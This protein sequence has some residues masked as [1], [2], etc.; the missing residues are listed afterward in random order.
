[1]YRCKHELIITSTSINIPCETS[2]KASPDKILVLLVREGVKER[3]DS[4]S[5]RAMGKD[6][7]KATALAHSE[8]REDRQRTMQRPCHV[9]A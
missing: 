4:E 7:T 9:I 3:L 1:M 5:R 2:I 6:K 8:D